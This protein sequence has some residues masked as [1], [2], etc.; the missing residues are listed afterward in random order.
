V[1]TNDDFFQSGGHSM[2]AL[3]V[4]ARLRM[5]MGVKLSLQDAFQY[6][7]IA[8][9]ARRVD[10]LRS[11]PSRLTGF[12][13]IR[14]LTP[15]ASYPLSRAQRRMW[16]A[17]HGVDDQSGLNVTAAFAVTSREG[18]KPECLQ[19]ALDATVRRHETL[20]TRFEES[21]GTPVQIIEE[22]ARVMLET[23]DLRDRS[24]AAVILHD[25][26]R[27]EETHR[28]HLQR[29]PLLR[30][31]L[32]RMGDNEDVVLFSIHHIVSDAWSIEVML[33]DL[34]WYHA[35][36]SEPDKLP[37]DLPELDVQYKEY[38][39]YHDELL[40]AEAGHGE[41]WLE[42]FHRMPPRIEWL[43]HRPRPS[44]LSCRGARWRGDLDRSGIR[45]LATAQGVTEFMT[46]L[47]MVQILIFQITGQRDIVVGAPTAARLHP[48]FD[49]Q[50]GC[51]VNTLPVRTTIEDGWRV[52][53]VLRAARD[54]TL[55][56]FEHDAYPFDLLVQELHLPRES[57]RNPLFETAVV[58]Q[59]TRA[60]E[61][62]TEAIHRHSAIVGVN[63]LEPLTINVF[64]DLTFRFDEAKPTGFL[65]DYRADLFEERSIEALGRRFQTIA[66]RAL[67]DPNLPLSSLDQG[68]GSPPFADEFES[69]KFDFSPDS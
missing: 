21:S 68:R 6:H 23:T 35:Q 55:A 10:E 49:E 52:R 1:G 39:A 9:L 67:T 53:D 47:A 13:E 44:G 8:T 29:A 56:A 69:V 48:A 40:S 20:R 15:A 66:R 58:L 42:L 14:S 11:I 36:V 28:F 62:L 41:F 46:L 33:R 30:V 51:Y 25:L 61:A 38:V 16:F 26:R 54:T 24:D 27:A 65:I 5:E 3:R 2:A 17:H 34:L 45:T 37:D 22:D 32:V 60:S 43:T 19:K 64:F 57:S 12:R 31:H 63:A 7:T 18:L 50:I 4:V 59:N